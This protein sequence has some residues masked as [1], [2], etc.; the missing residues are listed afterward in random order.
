MASWAKL[1]SACPHM[2]TDTILGQILLASRIRSIPL[3]PFITISVRRMSGGSS[4]M[5][6]SD[7]SALEASMIHSN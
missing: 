4:L 3:C 2:M 6:S 7:S 1:K 5:I